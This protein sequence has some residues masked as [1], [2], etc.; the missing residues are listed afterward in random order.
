MHLDKLF[1]VRDFAKNGLQGDLAVGRCQVKDVHFPRGGPEGGLNGVL[2]LCN[3]TQVATKLPDVVDCIADRC[4][5]GDA[6]DTSFVPDPLVKDIIQGP[7]LVG[8]WLDG[9]QEAMS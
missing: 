3:L 9:L 6:G 7:E 8:R 1:D 5:G 4:E 2:L